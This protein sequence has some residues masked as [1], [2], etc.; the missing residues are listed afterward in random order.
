MK[1]LMI[2]LK[3]LLVSA[4]TTGSLLADDKFEKAK[5]I[6]HG[7]GGVDKVTYTNSIEAVDHNYR[8]GYELFEIDF[9][10]TKDNRLVCL[11]DWN[12]IFKRVF[13]RSPVVKQLTLKEYIDFRKYSDFTPMTLDQLIEW[14]ALHPS[15]KVITDVKAKNIEA[16]KLISTK[17]KDFSERFIPQIYKPEE[18][19]IVKNIGYKNIIWTLYRY[20][21]SNDDAI[22]EVKSM[23]LF[24]VTM[25]PGRARKKLALKLKDMKI[26]SYVHTINSLKTVRQLS[27]DYGV[28][29]VY[30][31]FLPP[32]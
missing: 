26:P 12:I 2:F 19:K 23:N 25:T 3:C 13:P 28:T 30:T 14:L 17:V 18:Y 31:D 10:W 27:I 7:G 5:R 21:G 11:H 29:E 16:L 9:S 8:L 4:V 20:R 1:K 15:A 32:Y 24:A 22:K 6:A